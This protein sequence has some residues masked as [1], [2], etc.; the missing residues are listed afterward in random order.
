MIDTHA[1]I[2][3]SEFDSDRASMVDR[4]LAS[5]VSQILLPGIDLDSVGPMA[6]LCRDYPSVCFPMLALHPTSVDAN[7]M[8]I[9]DTLEPFLDQL[10]LVAIGETG[11]DLYWDD[12]WKEQQ[13]KV[14]YRHITWAK[15]KK[16]PLVIHSRNAHSDLV[17][18]LRSEQDGSLSG[19]FHCFGGSYEQARDILNLGFHLGIGGVVTFQN[20][21]LAKVVAQLGIASLVLETDAPYLAPVPHRGTR[22]EPA[23][24]E[25]IATKIAEV[26][27]HTLEQVQ[28][29][30]TQN[31]R[32]I[33]G[34]V[35]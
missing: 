13:I 26:S 27:G 9:M 17:E 23:Y 14:F 11:M 12:T 19:V 15:A 33:F 5:G 25:F 7:A 31:A 34:L 20:A 24:L 21:R 35:E 3:A 28:E 22:N 6:A 30:T 32:R 10:P 18:A 2:Y 1:H 8:Q 16:I 4:A 29:V